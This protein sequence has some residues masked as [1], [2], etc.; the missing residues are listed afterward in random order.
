MRARKTIKHRDAIIK[1]I[2][3][4]ISNKTDPFAKTSTESK[5]NNKPI[6]II[7]GGIRA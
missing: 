6:I 4:W 1:G 7:L 2:K 5:Q 3:K